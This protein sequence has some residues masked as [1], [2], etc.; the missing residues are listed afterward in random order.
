MNGKADPSDGN[1]ESSNAC[2]DS[3]LSS[4]T[5]S[6]NKIDWAAFTELRT[7]VSTLTLTTVIFVALRIRHRFLRRFRDATSIP[8]SYLRRRSIFGQVTSV[9]DGD[10]FRIFHTPGGRLAGWGWLPWKKIP[11][12][13][14]VLK[15]NTVHI[16]LAG[17]DA[18]EMA[19]FGRPEQPFAREAHAW[20]TR[21]LLH[22][23]VRVYAH[24]HDQ[25]QRVVASVYVRRGFEFPLPFRRRDVSYEMLRRGLATL[26]EAKSGAEYGGEDTEMKYRRAEQWAKTLGRG[27]WKD[28]RKSGGK[29][30]ESPR[31]YKTRMAAEELRKGDSD[32]REAKRA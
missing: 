31:E 30:W 4:T 29:E 28:F 25:Y 10:N 20:L 6:K 14:N 13:K 12:S 21:Y 32:F 2:Q 15:D 23:R 7:V 22:R 17:I 3:E 18:P 24:R 19:H 26:Y 5:L 8:P 9:G 27:L 1:G 11:A 16:R